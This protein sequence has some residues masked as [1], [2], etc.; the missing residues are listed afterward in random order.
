M[1]TS[2]IVIVTTGFP[3]LPYFASFGCSDMYSES[4]PMKCIV[5]G[6][7]CFLP[8]FLI[9]NYLTTLLYIGMSLMS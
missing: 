9:H 3:G 8:G 2:L 5:G 1:E 6:L 4:P 7:F